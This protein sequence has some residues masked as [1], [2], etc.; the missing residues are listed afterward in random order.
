VQ[1]YLRHPK[2]ISLKREEDVQYWTR[3]FGVSSSLLK[4]TIKNVGNSVEAVADV[5]ARSDREPVK[6]MDS[7]HR[8]P[9]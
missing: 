7:H 9:I 6:A 5:L 1:T 3:R 8:S 4:A 2:R